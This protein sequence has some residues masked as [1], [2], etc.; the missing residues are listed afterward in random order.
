VPVTCQELLDRL[1]EQDLECLGPNP[2][3]K[4][5]FWVYAGMVEGPRQMPGPPHPNWQWS[6][7]SLVDIR[8]VIELQKRGFRR[9][10]AIVCQ[11]W[12]EGRGFPIPMVRNYML[13]EFRRANRLLL[14]QVTSTLGMR[15]DKMSVGE[16]Q[17]RALAR[18]LGP[19]DGSFLTANID[20]GTAGFITGY[21]IARFGE[22][23]IVERIKN[24]PLAKLLMDL[25]LENGIHSCAGLLESD[26]VAELSAEKA[27]SELSDLEFLQ[28]RDDANSFPIM[29]GWLIF[30]IDALF[31]KSPEATNLKF[32]AE[33]ALR[34]FSRWP[35]L[36]W[37]F[38]FCAN[39]RRNARFPR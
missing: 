34:S 2:A 22:A 26:E 20:V 13:S 31:P 17:L 28:V 27:I 32:A 29:L 21:E 11:R 15:N 25:K 1:D 33:K 4:L 8:A 16:H 18:Q 39:V 30:G 12:L 5:E 9:T 10:S 7:Q 23:S 36:I 35:W 14:R 6:E 37:A 3:R 38:G 19:L 24:T